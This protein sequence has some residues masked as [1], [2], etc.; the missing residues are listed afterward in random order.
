[1]LETRRTIYVFEEFQIDA[2][3][4]ILWRAGQTVPLTSKAFEL[5]LALV[6]N[7]G[8]ELTKEE[9]MERIWGDQIVEEGNLTVTMSY[10]R[11]ALGEKAN[12]HRLI[13]TI[14][15]RGYRFVAEV[16]N[17]AEQREF[18]IESKTA[19]QVTIEQEISEADEKLI[20]GGKP[21]QPAIAASSDLALPG[22]PALTAIA[23]P[24][25]AGKKVRAP[26]NRRLIA[27]VSSIALLAIAVIAYYFWN[28]HTPATTTPRIKSI[29]VLPFKPLVAQSRDESLEMGMAD[30]LI[31]RLSNIREINVRPI[32]SVR[33]YSALDQDPIAAGQEQQ[34][35]A[36]LDGQILK[37]GE[38]VR[39][40]VR[41]LRIA[42]GA[43][44][45]SSQFDEKMTDIFTVQDSISERVTSAL[46]VKLTNEEQRGITKRYT[47]DTEAYQL[48]LHGRYQLNRLTD[49][50]FL[51]G[52]DFFQQ[53]IQKD[54]NYALAYAGL[55]DAYNRLGGF[56]ALAS[57][58]AFPKAKDAAQQ[59][60]KLDE[61]LA[62][63]HSALA[64]V[65]FAYEWNF[66][67][68]EQEFRRAIE[69]N[70][71]YSDAH[72][73][74]GFYLAAMG[75]FDEALREMKRALELDPLS[76]EKTTGI[77]E[78]LY[79]QRKYDEAIAQ[80]RKA[81]EMDSNSG[82]THWAMGRPL[83][84]QGKFNEAI[85][86]FQK[87]IPLSGDS[88][89]EPAELAR[90]Y[91]MSGRRDEALKIVAELKKLSEHKHVAPTVMASIYAALGD[92]DQAFALLN[93]AFDERDFILTLVK[94][95]PMFDPLRSD[96][97]FPEL[98][99]RVGLSE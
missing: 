89:D 29:A 67:A 9:L 5:L 36:V 81:L 85:G 50:G 53:A 97:R 66:V 58:E 94:V 27:F 72:Q 16:S 11:K 80:F 43:P 33:K 69:L 21:R 42:D 98:A 73:M 4:R 13:V 68:A 14:P 59:A 65:N 31:A 37:A 82:F 87:S 95:E 55:A 20:G 91:A 51:K 75:R 19:S 40:T 15:G 8:R 88:P 41:L 96:P 49:D 79:H 64:T 92:N 44:L 38:K 6:E 26:G 90:A 99:R 57:S 28:K 2:Q 32:S 71:N 63:A 70:P 54:S 10:V 61:S 23:L 1:M 83:L 30:T 77:G 76:L 25:I 86:E 74:N 52:R 34:V 56:D 45:W 39:V 84:A 24:A 48:Y 47:A 46:A 62:E 17:L 35:D 60:L 3:K 22:A 78:I 12:D 18:I 93:R 7:H